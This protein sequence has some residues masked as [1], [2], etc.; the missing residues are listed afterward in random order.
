MSTLLSFLRKRRTLD[1]HP[2]WQH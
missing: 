2:A 1:L